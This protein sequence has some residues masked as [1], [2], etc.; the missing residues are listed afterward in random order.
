M[1]RLRVVK[2]RA[3][4]TQSTDFDQDLRGLGNDP[5]LRESFPYTV[6]T[7][8]GASTRDPLVPFLRK[9]D[10]EALALGDATEIHLCA[11]ERKEGAHKEHS[12]VLFI[13]ALDFVAK[14]PGTAARLDFYNP[15]QERILQESRGED[16]GVETS[17]VE[18]LKSW[19]S[20]GGVTIASAVTLG[21]EQAGFNIP[22][23]QHHD[24]HLSP[25]EVR[26]TFEQLRAQAQPAAR[27]RK[28]G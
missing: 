24:L 5:I 4:E 7:V 20:R 9:Y 26:T 3:T 27:V 12:V 28:V 6:L 18:K 17:F 16:H 13:A 2:E 8:R 15:L 23:S 22:S 21:L 10:L 19:D 11:K 14:I 1:K 25:G